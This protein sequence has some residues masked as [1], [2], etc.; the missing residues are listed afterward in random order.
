VA[1][2]QKAV[3][4]EDAKSYEEYAKIINEQT[5]RPMNL[6]GLWDFVPAGPAVPLEES[7]RPSRS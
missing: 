3:R 7:S 6:R 5:D 2:L 4:A 1:S